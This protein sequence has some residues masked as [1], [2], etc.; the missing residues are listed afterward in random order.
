MGENIM[1][2]RR[3]IALCIVFT[4]ITCGIYGLYWMAKVQDESLYASQES[5]TSGGMVVLLSIVTCGIYGLYWMYTLGK[6]IDK[7][8]QNPSGSSNIIYL[9]L[10]IC[11]LGIVSLCLAQNELN[12]KAN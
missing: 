2:K 1:A 3:E 8:T 11:G 9:I 5:G 4:I 6:R 10:S 7:I 12:A